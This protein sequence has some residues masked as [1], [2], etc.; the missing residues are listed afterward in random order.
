MKKQ[1][2][3]LTRKLLGHYAYFRVI[4]NSRSLVSYWYQ[5]K[6][7]WFKWLNRR[8]NRGFSWDSMHERLERYPLPPPRMSSRAAN[9]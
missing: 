9:P 3:A 1:Y 2:T 6:A 5:V 7:I 4:G 8:S